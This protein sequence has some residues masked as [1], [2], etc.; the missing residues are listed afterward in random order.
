[1]LAAKTIRGG[2]TQRSDPGP[3][4]GSCHKNGYYRKAGSR[5]VTRSFSY[6]SRSVYQIRLHLLIRIKLEKS[7]LFSVSRFQIF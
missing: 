3:K 2:V 1:M 4:D 7:L 5:Y 6:S